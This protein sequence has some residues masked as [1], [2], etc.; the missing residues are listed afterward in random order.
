MHDEE[1]AAD[2]WAGADKGV[3]EVFFMQWIK[4][5]LYLRSV[6]LRASDD[7]PAEPHEARLPSACR[8]TTVSKASDIRREVTVRSCDAF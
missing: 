2:L 7:E 4:T 1:S 6:E 3:L 8:N 5:N